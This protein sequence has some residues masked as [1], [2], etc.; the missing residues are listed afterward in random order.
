MRNCGKAVPGKG[1]GRSF[2]AIGIGLAPAAVRR[3]LLTQAQQE[4]RLQSGGLMVSCCVDGSRK[5]GEA[6]LDHDVELGVRSKAIGKP[7]DPATEYR[8]FAY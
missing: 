5:S 1:P 4:S 3:H 2:E 7:F 6:D 8:E